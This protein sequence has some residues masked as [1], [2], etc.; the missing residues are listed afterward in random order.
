MRSAAAATAACEDIATR[1]V[2]GHPAPPTPDHEADTAATAAAPGALIT[3]VASAD[4]ATDSR[5]FGVRARTRFR[6]TRVLL[7]VAALIALWE[8]VALWFARTLEHPEYVMP[9]L[10]YVLRV[11]LPGLSDYYSG[12]FGGT[13]PSQGGGQT[14]VQGLLSLVEHSGISLVRVGAGLALG[15]ALGI[16]AGLAMAALRPVRYAGFGVANLLR[17]L[18]LLA[19]GPLFTLWLGPTTSASV[20]FIC[21]AVTLTMLVATSNAIGNLD[22]DLLAYPRTLGL[23]TFAT[24]RRVV[25]PA[26]IPELAAALTICGPLA[27][28]VLLASEMYGMQEGLGWMMSEALDFTLVDRITLIAV[29]FIVLNFVTLRAMQALVRRGTRWAE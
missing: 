27:W 24:Y 26:I 7:G 2:R 17:M 8:A 25:A 6:P 12:V 14:V 16:A 22:P 15:T 9:E 18:P 29:A 3:P 5:S 11:G 13:P 4:G 28:S 23:S 10:G 19:L 20:T 1:V 21:F